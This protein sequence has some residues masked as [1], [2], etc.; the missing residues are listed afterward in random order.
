M[1][2]DKSIRSLNRLFF[3]QTRVIWALLMREVITRYGRNNI[4]FLWAFVEPLFFTFG[5]AALWA[6]T[7]S[8]HGSKL[9]VIPFVVTGYATVLLWRNSTGRSLVAIESNRSLL[10]HR[11]VTLLD[12]FLARFILE[13]LTTTFSFIVVELFM[14][15]LGFMEPPSSIF[16][17][18]QGWAILAIFSF[19]L[20]TT[21]GCLNSLSDIVDR[22]WHPIS[23]FMMPLSGAFFLVDWLP[24][25]VQSYAVFVPTVT[26]TE[27]MRS[28]QFGSSIRT[29]YDIQYF[30]FVSLAFVLIALLLTKVVRNR[31]ECE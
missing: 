31:L 24:S 20:S 28:G 25:S 11:N 8:I 26:A 7:S 14:I 29:H 1:R 30:L 13:F 18:L 15:T 16:P 17:M 2:I 6:A 3:T 9:P 4:G 27:L 12:I 19:G 23:Y 5:I 21:L 10:Y 22:F